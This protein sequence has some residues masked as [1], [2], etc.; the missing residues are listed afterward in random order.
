MFTGL[1]TR[2]GAAVWWSRTSKAFAVERRGVL[3]SF[4]KL[5]DQLWFGHDEFSLLKGGG[6]VFGREW[7]FG[8]GGAGS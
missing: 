3:G 2:E 1:W 6:Q 8:E 7:K 4:D 5:T